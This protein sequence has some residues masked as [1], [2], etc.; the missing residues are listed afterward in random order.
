MRYHVSCGG[1]GEAM[2]KKMRL[3]RERVLWN[4]RDKAFNFKE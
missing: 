1:K 4:W 2:E 3:E